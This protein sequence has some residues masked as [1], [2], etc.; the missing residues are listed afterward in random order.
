[1]SIVQLDARRLRPGAMTPPV[2][3]SDALR[4]L[5]LAAIRGLPPPAVGNEP[6]EDV[7]VMEAGLATLRQ[8][9]GAVDCGD[10]AGPLRILLGQ[11]AVCAGRAMFTGS[12]RL[13]E[14]PHAP[15]IDALLQSLG[16]VGLRIERGAPWPWIVDGTEKTAAPLFRARADLSSQIATSLLLAAA[17]RAHRE[18]RAWE[19]ELQGPVASTG[20]LEVTT[21]WL[22]TAGFRVTTKGGRHSVASGE[23]PRSL[24][25][26]PADWSSGAYLLI[27]AWRSG[28]TV[29]GLDPR[30]THPDRAIVQ[31]LGEVGL[32]VHCSADH[33]WTVKGNASAG[34]RAS[35]ADC[36]D[37]VP[38]LV[39]LACVLPGPSTFTELGILR[40]KESDRV[41]GA[42]EIARAGGA[43][44]SIEGS[45][46]RLS[47][48]PR[49]AGSLRLSSQGDH[50]L[51]MA[52]STLAVC[53]EE[54][55]ALEGWECVR[56]SFPA[57]FR[58]LSHI[59]V[60]VC[61]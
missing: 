46:L 11:A 4:A 35:A 58:E 8:G 3:K 25:A 32:E 19:V 39:A 7:R 41:A 16:E 40:S 2:S 38:T 22:A 29:A 54:E 57:F 10:G 24:P 6:P 28:G 15:L 21:R 42:L 44:A 36:P 34:L 53:L 49:P 59:G 48:R 60:T 1:M 26:L 12:A 55:I 27:A 33:T 13:A 43:Q 17:N 14:R 30:A 9:T 5:A 61:T 47:P 45:E 37:L 51:A 20:Y 50:R 31:L 23:P 52:A 56:K 18:G